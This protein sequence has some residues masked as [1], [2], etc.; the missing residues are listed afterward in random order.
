[1][2]GR[3]G[4]RMSRMETVTTDTLYISW[5]V[6]LVNQEDFVKKKK[7]KIYIYIYK[8]FILSTQFIISRNLLCM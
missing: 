4:V 5:H 1:M 6:M 2:G 7:K 3:G 8:P